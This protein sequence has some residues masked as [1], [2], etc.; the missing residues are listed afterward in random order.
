MVKIND[1]RILQQIKPKNR[2]IHK[3]GN[4]HTIKSIKKAKSRSFKRVI[5]HK[6]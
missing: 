2:K 5:N 4:V 1:I 3:I 6:D